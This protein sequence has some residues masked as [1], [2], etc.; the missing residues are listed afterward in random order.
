MEEY[1]TAIM[2]DWS[3]LSSLNALSYK[4]IKTSNLDIITKNMLFYTK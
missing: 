3:T 2:T 4:Q 1:Y